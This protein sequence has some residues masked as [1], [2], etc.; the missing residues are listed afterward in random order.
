MH[1]LESTKLGKTVS[2]HG[3]LVELAIEQAEINSEI[4]PII[5]EDE[6]VDRYILCATNALPYFSVS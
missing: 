2:G 3:E 1:I 4:D 6:A 5:I